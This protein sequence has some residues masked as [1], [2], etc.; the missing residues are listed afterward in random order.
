MRDKPNLCLRTLTLSLIFAF[1]LMPSAFSQN[2]PQFRGE[3][4][5]GYLDNT[6]IP[7]KWDVEKKD[8]LKWKTEI[9]G[10]GHS[11]PVIWGDKLFVTTA[12]SASGNDGLKV[13]LYGDIDEDPDESVH[14]FKV[15]CLNK[16][17]GEIVWDQLAHEDVPITHRHTKSSHANPTPATDGKHLVAFFGSE[18]LFCYDLD[19]NLLWKKTWVG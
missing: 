18:G 5:I 4:G 17:T 16:N 7:V 19:G 12:I 13:G 9:P 15:Y 8:N 2:W 3:R 10:L 14:Q 11:C 6:N 1:C